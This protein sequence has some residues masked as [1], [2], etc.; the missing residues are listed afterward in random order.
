MIEYKKESRHIAE[1]IYIQFNQL[2]YTSLAV[3]NMQFGENTIF[4]I[5]KSQYSLI[6][7]IKLIE[8]HN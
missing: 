5:R 4:E 1:Y 3:L 7:F 8:C 6:N 2:F